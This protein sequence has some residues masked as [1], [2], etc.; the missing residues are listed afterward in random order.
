MKTSDEIMKAKSV[1]IFAWPFRF[2]RKKSVFKEMVKKKGWKEKSIKKI[3]NFQDPKANDRDVADCFMLHQYLSHSAKEIFIYNDICSI[4]DYPFEAE[5]NY[6]YYFKKGSKEFRLPIA[7]IQLHVYDYGVGILFIQVW[8]QSYNDI[9]DIK[10]I[11]DYGR[12]VSLPY[13]S[14][15]ELLCADELGICLDG[16]MV[17]KTD[18]KKASA[19]YSD[20]DDAKTALQQAGFLFALLNCN[21]NNT[22]ENDI[23]VN[24]HTDDRMFVF[25]LIRDAELSERVEES[26]EYEKQL[27]SILFV[28]SSDA[29]CQN[30]EM[31]KQLFTK[32][33][34]PRWSDYGTLYGATSYSL[35]CI[36][37]DATV[38]NENVVR[39]FLAEY[40]Y[41]ASLVLAQRIG[42][43]AF[44]AHSGKVVSGLNSK[45]N[46]WKSGIGF[47]RAARLSWIQ[48][49]YIDFKNRLL[50]LE[51]STQE[52][53]IEIYQLLQRQFLVK[54]E[55]EILDGKLQSLYEAANISIGNRLAVI[56]L[57]LAAAALYPNLGNK[58]AEKAYKLLMQIP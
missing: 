9:A 52:Q 24:P 10:W 53:G 56:G 44:T 12:R 42:I 48:K 35:C 41:I 32:A 21:L 1:H 46:W 36:T 20:R 6:E 45:M 43:I 23:K 40:S 57:I 15:G 11:N 16:S 13:L 58:I 7:A 22:G 51:A 3:L 14:N 54:E 26:Q 50:I 27:Y 4:Y 34:Y 17:Q 33:V 30:R 28:D 18:F 2:E 49:Q 38:V 19:E 39:P 37:T 8:N 55:Q 47:F 5:K 29:T 31:R 25:S